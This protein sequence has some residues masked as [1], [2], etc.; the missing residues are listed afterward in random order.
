MA[1]L[2]IVYKIA[3]PY[4]DEIVREQLQRTVENFKHIDLEK[5][6]VERFISLKVLLGQLFIRLIFAYFTWE[7]MQR[8]WNVSLN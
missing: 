5:G 8:E 4:R 2:T 7:H 1:Y 6:N 3:D